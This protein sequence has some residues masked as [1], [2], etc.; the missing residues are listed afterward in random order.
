MP[1]NAD[2]K[3]EVHVAA[4]SLASRIPDFWVDM[5]EVWFARVN[6]ILAPQKLSDEIKFDLIL[7][8]LSKETISELTEIILDPP[9]TEKCKALKIKLLALYEDTNNARIKKL[10][11]DIELGDQKPSQLLRKMKDLAKKNFPDETLRILWEERLPAQVRAVL[12]VTVTKDLNE[13]AAVADKVLEA[14]RPVQIAEIA[15]QQPQQGTSGNAD[16]VTIMAEI[17]KLNARFDNL[18]RAR[19]RSRS[20]QRG[21]PNTPRPSPSRKREDWLCF[22]HFRYREQARKC[23]QPCAWNGRT[24]PAPTFTPGN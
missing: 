5:P 19:P 21:R 4:V 17:A 12:A 1:D 23:L 11:R 24:T 9:D 10:L 22:Y 13:L 3:D 14:A 16:T 2:V 8:K 7:S 6:A 20:T 18:V 15:Q